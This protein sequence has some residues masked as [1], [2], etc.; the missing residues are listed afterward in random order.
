MPMVYYRRTMTG[1]LK[2]GS[3]M[4]VY[5]GSQPDHQAP[6]ICP[7]L[8]MCVCNSHLVAIEFCIWWLMLPNLGQELKEFSNSQG[9]GRLRPFGRTIEKP[10]ESGETDLQLNEG[11]GSRKETHLKVKTD[12][13]APVCLPVSPHRGTRTL[14]RGQTRS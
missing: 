8:V 9:K 13:E 5:S 14:V 10:A 6:V 1:D 2:T 12:A 4:P 11:K 7:L 3:C